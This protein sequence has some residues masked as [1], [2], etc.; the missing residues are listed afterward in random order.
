M[1]RKP[2]P[3]PGVNAAAVEL[4]SASTELLLCGIDIKYAGKHQPVDD[5]AWYRFSATCSF[6]HASADEFITRTAPSTSTASI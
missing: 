3:A 4:E 1:T 6:F 2:G 5:R